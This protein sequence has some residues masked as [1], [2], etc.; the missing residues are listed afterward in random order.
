MTLPNLLTLARILA[1]PFFAISLWYGHHGKACAI[2]AVAGFTDL[3][4]GYIARKFDMKSDLGAILDPMADKLLMT[5][6]FILLAFPRNHYVAPV[7]AWVAILAISRDLM[8]SLFSFINLARGGS[9][10]GRPSFL[11]KVTTATQ[12]IA[13]S[14]GLLMN[15]LGPQSWQR[16]LNPWMYYLVAALVLA[17]GIHYYLRSHRE[18]ASSPA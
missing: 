10:M 4:D 1:I 12:L 2:F 6:A 15:A 5:T 7:P 3:L 14:L 17:S 16:W 8:I 18:D 11:G 9:L 13:I